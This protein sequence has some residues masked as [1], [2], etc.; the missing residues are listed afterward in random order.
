MNS[1]L[2]YLKSAS[3]KLGLLLT[4]INELRV[5]VKHSCKSIEELWDIEKNSEN[6]STF[7]FGAFPTREKAQSRALSNSDDDRF[8]RTSTE[9]NF[10][11]LHQ[12]SLKCLARLFK[13]LNDSEDEIKH[14]QRIAFEWETNPP[15]FIN[16]TT[17]EFPEK[18]GQGINHAEKMRTHSQRATRIFSRKY[19]INF[20]RQSVD[21]YEKDMLD[22]S[23]VP[24]IVQKDNASELVNLIDRWLAEA[25]E[26]A[27]DVELEKL[28]PDVK[29]R[30][31]GI[32]VSFNNVIKAGISLKYE[33]DDGS[34]FVLLSRLAIF[35]Y[36]ERKTIND[37]SDFLLFQR[38][39]QIAMDNLSKFDQEDMIPTLLDWISNYHDIFS[40]TCHKCEKHLA[41][42]NSEEKFMLPTLRVLSPEGQLLAFHRG[43]L[44]KDNFL[45]E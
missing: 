13:M 9:K 8:T 37:S 16:P 25:K 11:K 31:S 19:K 41:L 24:K 38:L 28:K 42:Q 26:R 10:L 3:D 21:L 27:Y 17:K 14:G 39:T 32:M 40:V 7:D 36:H 33:E 23:S 34:T 43:C 1:E 20:N 45:E 18:L 35:G 29:G 2:D 44:P 6:D 12:D 22:G 30:L 15:I 5:S 4:A